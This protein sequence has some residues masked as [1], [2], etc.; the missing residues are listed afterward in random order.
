MPIL[1]FYSGRPH[2]TI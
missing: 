2:N 1:S